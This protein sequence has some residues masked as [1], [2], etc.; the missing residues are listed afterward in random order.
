MSA[1][2]TVGYDPFDPAVALDPYPIYAWLRDDAPVHHA[3]STDTFVLSRFDDVAWAL[4]ET[5]LLSSDAMRGVLLGQPT[6]KGRER[7][8][9]AAAMGTIVAVDP[10]AHTEM[11]RIVNRGFT[12]KRISGWQER[13]AVLVDEL[14]SSSLMSGGWLSGGRLS[15]GWLSGGPPDYFDV[16]TGLAAPLPVMVI[17]ELLGA[18]PGHADQFRE[19]ADTL[20]R[21]MSGSARGA[22]MFTDDS[23]SQAVFGLAGYLAGQ[24]EA[25]QREPRDDLLGVLVRA[26]GDDVLE[27]TEALGFAALL[28]FAGSETTTNLI[29]NA[30]WALLTHPTE[31]AR[32]ASSPDRLPAVLEETLRWESPVQYV[33]RRAT[34]SFDLHGVTIPEDATVTLVLGA[35]NRDPR[36][37]GESAAAFDPDRMTA[38]HV[39]FGFGPHFCLGAA[40]AR[41]EAS[42]AI[43]RLLPGLAS[44]QLVSQQFVDSTQFRGRREL[45][46]ARAPE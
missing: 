45:T 17:A 37:F 31:L 11:R 22:G 44:A 30:V 27:H 8:P 1:P 29:G 34:A 28:L 38:G 32:L 18:D 26:H 46:I 7:L 16:V 2:S 40:L 6:G 35:A 39:G 5:D 10:P 41:A 43:S 23:T 4:G 36:H 25:R 13:I 42:T 19:W 12:P 9:R 33:F 24:I 21:A 20:T 14:L 15:G 3:T